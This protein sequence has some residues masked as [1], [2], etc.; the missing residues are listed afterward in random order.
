MTDPNE[1]VGH[2]TL[3]DSA[4]QIYHEP[5]TRG[6]ADS[7]WAICEARTAER[8][9]LMPDEATARRLFHDAYTRL[10]DFGWKDAIYSPKDGSAFHAI[11]EGSTG[12]HVCRYHGEWPEGAGWIDD[13][14]SRPVFYRP[15]PSESTQ[16]QEATTMQHDNNDNQTTA[17]DGQAVAQNPMQPAIQGYRKFDQETSDFI[18][19]VKE[20]GKDIDALLARAGILGADPRALALAKTN[21]QQGAMWLIR[22]AAQPDGL[23]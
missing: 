2:K 11:E 8:N 15:I 23:F 21:L 14:T 5:L 6:E 19:S 3:Q 17:T 9:A 7:L 4:G 13:C 10:K 16:A 18:N 12:T 1:I 20:A 22:A